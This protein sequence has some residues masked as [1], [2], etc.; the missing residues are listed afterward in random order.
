MRQ[1]ATVERI[2]PDGRAD[3]IVVRQSAC[4]GDC[5]QCGG[6]GSMKQT[7]R[8]TAENPIGAKCGEKVW[9]ES[10]SADVLKGAAL[11]Y[12]LP[13]V[14]FL[15][16]YLLALPLGSRAFA[17]AVGAFAVGFLPAFAYNRKIKREPPSY[18]VVGYVK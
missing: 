10:G 18:T 6:C 3:L 1:K 4:S 8:V 13:L 17:V 16:A 14:L 2:L 5:H 12:L 11:V 7:L 15:A 9:V